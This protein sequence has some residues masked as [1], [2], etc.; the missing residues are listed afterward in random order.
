ML[1]ISVEYKQYPFIPMFANLSALAYIPM[2]W[3]DEWAI[4][5]DDLA[6]EWKN[7]VGIA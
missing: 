7:Q 4:I 6:D 3:A 5:P 2:A 1:Q